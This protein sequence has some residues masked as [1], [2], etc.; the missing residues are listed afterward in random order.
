MSKGVDLKKPLNSFF[1]YRK[2]IKEEVKLKYGIIKN[3]DVN[4]KIAELW[5][6]ESKE[7]KDRYQELSLQEHLRFKE[8]NPDFDWQPWKKNKPKKRLRKTSASPTISKE[9][10]DCPSPESSHSLPN[11]QSPKFSSVR[12]TKSYNSLE[13]YP[14]PPIMS[15]SLF[16]KVSPDVFQATLLETDTPEMELNMDDFISE[17]SIGSPLSIN[18]DF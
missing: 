5:A 13:I 7:T 16:Y 1:L 18:F 10:A 11:I 6:K 3:Q 14:Q 12:L 4:K 15:P 9:E 8:Q 2:H 17:G